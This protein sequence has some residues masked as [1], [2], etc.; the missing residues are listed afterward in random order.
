MLGVPNSVMR[1]LVSMFWCALISRPTCMALRL[2]LHR[3]IMS[4][5]TSDPMI[6]ESLIT[7]LPC[8]E[9]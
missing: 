3:A 9:W 1:V 2:G 4:G 8:G 7:F 6:A 5:S